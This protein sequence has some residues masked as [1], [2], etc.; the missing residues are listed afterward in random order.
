MRRAA[1]RVGRASILRGMNDDVGLEARLLNFVELFEYKVSDLMSGRDPIGGRRSTRELRAYLTDAP[2]V[3][4][5]L[6]RFREMDQKYRALDLSAGQPP[7]QEGGASRPGFEV[8]L[9][10]P[11][12]AAPVLANLDFGL[13]DTLPA[14]GGTAGGS[15]AELA[16]L[17]AAGVGSTAGAALDSEGAALD[18]LAI[19]AWRTAFEDDLLDQNSRL[20]AEPSHP[21][22]RL[23]S[24]VLINLEQYAQAPTFAT[25]V[26]LAKFSVIASVPA[27][28]DPLANFA[29]PQVVESLLLDL[30]SK[31]IDFKRIFPALSIAATE[32]LPYLRRFTLAVADAPHA[33][34]VAAKGGP[35]LREVEGALDSARQENLPPEAKRHLI[36]S[37]SGQVERVKAQLRGRQESLI[38][39]R[40]MLKAAAENLF[41]WL[42]DHIPERLGGRGPQI[43]AL[44]QAIQAARDD[45]RLE[46][47]QPDATRVAVRLVRPGGTRL[48]N[49]ELEWREGPDGWLLEIGGAEYRLAD[50]L[51]VPFG[52]HEIRVFR[53]ESYA[54]FISRDREGTGLWGALGLARCTAALLQPGER[55]QNMRLVHAATTWLRD[56]RLDPLAFGPAGAD[57]LDS[58][59]EDALANFARVRAERFLE[60]LRRNPT[61]GLTL[62]ALTTAARILAEPGA[63]T[64]AAKLARLFEATLRPESRAPV[65]GLDVK[66]ENDVVVVAYRGE[67][68]TVRVLGRAFTLRADHSG[69]V[70][71]LFPG[72]GA[73]EV[74]PVLPQ[75]VPGG[76][77]LMARE[78]LRIAVGFTPEL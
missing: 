66:R 50:S 73:R 3:G 68:V 59:S 26:N 18:A 72:G 61:P 63:L 39:E 75:P 29:N 19:S 49:I 22:L 37:L 34:E 71:A 69:R 9:S 14:L 11:I 45:R 47:L 56:R 53:A 1:R 67:P 40:R 74:A 36:E 54:L 52:G 46:S 62:Q 21:T 64:P 5:L 32:A 31:I 70:F 76:F 57:R 42:S 30:A 28:D 24:A 15:P 8:S 44:T 4:H 13:L 48:G 51:R 33:G 23:V 12:S 16:D 77:V 25:D 2:L 6:R 17:L 78:G 38:S 43:V 55:Y 27:V 58:A 7:A 41:G 60:R 10:F 35:S 20:R 65:A